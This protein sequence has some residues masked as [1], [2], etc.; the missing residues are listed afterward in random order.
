MLGGMGLGR[1]GPRNLCS[2]LGM[3]EWSGHP[4]TLQRYPSSSIHGGTL[5][6]CWRNLEI[7]RSGCWGLVLRHKDEIICLSVSVWTSKSCADSGHG[8]SWPKW[9]ANILAQPWHIG[10]NPVSLAVDPEEPEGTRTGMDVPLGKQS[11]AL[12]KAWAW[13]M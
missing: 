10:G 12:G 11:M 5:H 8:C 3:M 6:I 1:P 13:R 2:S 9:N 7:S 4:L